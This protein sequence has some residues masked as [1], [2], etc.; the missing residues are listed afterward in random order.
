VEPDQCNAEASEGE[1]VRLGRIVTQLLRNGPKA[2]GDLTAAAVRAFKEGPSL[3][4]V[5]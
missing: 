1:K 2:V 5:V 4:E 3:G